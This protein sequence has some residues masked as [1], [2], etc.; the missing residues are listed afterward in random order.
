MALLEIGQPYPDPTGLAL[1]LH[2]GESK[3]AALLGRGTSALV[4]RREQL[5]GDDRQHRG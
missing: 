5:R 4:Q 1:E 3:P 2:P